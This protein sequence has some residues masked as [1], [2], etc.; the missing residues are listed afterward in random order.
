MYGFILPL[1]SVT[2]YQTNQIRN[3]CIDTIKTL[4]K[5]TL[6]N[7]LLKIGLTSSY[8]ANQ[9]DTKVSTA[10]ETEDVVSCTKEKKKK[11]RMSWQDCHGRMTVTIFHYATLPTKSQIWQGMCIKLFPIVI[12]GRSPA[13]I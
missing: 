13:Y 9:S 5:S 2:L 6:K 10:G 3:P 12:S 7:V 11:K 8:S 1:K 4:G